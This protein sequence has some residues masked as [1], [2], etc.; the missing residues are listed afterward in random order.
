MSRGPIHPAQLPFLWTKMGVLWLLKSTALQR[1]LATV[2]KMKNITSQEGEWLFGLGFFSPLQDIS[3]QLQRQQSDFSPVRRKLSGEGCLFCLSSLPLSEFSKETGLSLRNTPRF[4]AMC[5]C[6][7]SQCPALWK[8]ITDKQSLRS[9][10]PAVYNRNNALVPFIIF[11]YSLCLMKT[12]RKFFWTTFVF[13]DLTS[14]QAEATEEGSG[15]L[16]GF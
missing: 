10:P 15:F 6:L 13:Y 8:S 5:R 7:R 11:Y 4:W 9:K 3:P 16:R 1:L 14:L 2:K 12:L